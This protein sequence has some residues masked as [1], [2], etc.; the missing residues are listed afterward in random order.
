[1]RRL[2]ARPAAA[3]QFEA[4]E[5]RG[6]PE[7][8]AVQRAFEEREAGDVA[9]GEA[10][11]AGRAGTGAER[12]GDLLKPYLGFYSVWSSAEHGPAPQLQRGKNG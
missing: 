2:Q 1:M 5:Q 9:R 4:A 11:G 8:R 6:T 10:L 7:Q 12:P 3:H